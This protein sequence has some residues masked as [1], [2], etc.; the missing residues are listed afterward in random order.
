MRVAV[1]HQGNNEF[2]AE[3]ESALRFAGATHKPPTVDTQ[4]SKNLVAVCIVFL[5]K[6]QVIFFS[7]LTTFAAKI[8]SIFDKK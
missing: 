1:G 5:V 8:V 7:H 3:E 2:L 6:L 4:A